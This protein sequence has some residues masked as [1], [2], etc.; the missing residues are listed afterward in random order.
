MAVPQT[1]DPA[2]ALS[3]AL[4]AACT[5]A[6]AG[7]PVGSCCGN[8]DGS[9][10]VAWLPKQTKE[11]AAS[12]PRGPQGPW[13]R[14]CATCAAAASALPPFSLLSASLS[15]CLLGIATLF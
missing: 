6:G 7:V 9:H 14:D 8:T 13:P 5:Q 12:Q 11:K 4:T 15:E 3:S 10:V 2:K 1:A